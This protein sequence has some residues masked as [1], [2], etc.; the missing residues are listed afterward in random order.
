MDSPRDQRSDSVSSAGSSPVA[1]R[2]ASTASTGLFASL[3]DQKRSTDPQQQARR[4]SLHEQRP[5]SGFI[6]KMW[7]KL[8]SPR[9]EQQT[10]CLKCHAH[11]NA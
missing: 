2:R 8:S 4:L 6:G 11:A 10:T 3:H 5:K 9:L 1:P 7:N